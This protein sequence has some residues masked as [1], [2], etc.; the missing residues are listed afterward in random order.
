[1]P[2]LY[3]KSLSA[4]T[5]LDR[6]FPIQNTG[7]INRAGKSHAG[8]R[9]NFQ[10]MEIPHDADGNPAI[11]I[12][13]PGSIV[14]LVAPAGDQAFLQMK[15]G[16]LQLDNSLVT[17]A[18]RNLA[19]RV[20]K[21]AVKNKRKTTT[22]ALA[23]VEMK[24]GGKTVA[25]D[26]VIDRFLQFNILAFNYH[27]AIPDAGEF[28][29]EQYSP[30]GSPVPLEALILVYTPFLNRIEKEAMRQMPQAGGEAVLLRQVQGSFIK[31]VGKAVNKAAGDVGKGVEHAAND[32]GK[33]V[34]NA[35]T[36]VADAAVDTADGA[37]AAF[38]TLEGVNVKQTVQDAEDG[39]VY[40]VA[41]D[42]AGIG[43]NEAQGQVM[44]AAEAEGEEEAVTAAI[45]EETEFAAAGAPLRSQLLKTKAAQRPF[46]WAAEPDV[47]ELL[48]YRSFVFASKD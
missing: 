40:A 27:S 32:V 7:L 38:E 31:D 10:S 39:D 26:I 24:Y 43:E 22:D 5:I 23:L 3:R 28:S 48:D 47:D 44:D 36:D 9:V 19:T 4:R 25:A 2:L 45:A 20:G 11:G 21:L 42:L 16:A 35:A 1:M 15:E 30:S 37:N 46:T 6:H 41:G 12:G 18:A 33:G 34:E 29:L 17:I 14:L 8:L 13:T